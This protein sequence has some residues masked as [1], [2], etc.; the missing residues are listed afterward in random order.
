MTAGGVDQALHVDVR[1]RR[2]RRQVEAGPKK[3]PL[4]PVKHV[5]RRVQPDSLDHHPEPELALGASDRVLEVKVG[6]IASKPYRGIAPIVRHLVAAEPIGAAAAADQPVVG[7]VHERLHR[8]E[9]RPL[10]EARA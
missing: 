6:V 5:G 4:R 3:G 7:D 10:V 9:R 2:R 1:D 8:L